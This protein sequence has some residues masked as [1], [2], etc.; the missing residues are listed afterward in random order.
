MSRV[1]LALNV[2]TTDEVALATTRLNGEGLETQ[3]E[4]QT[5]CCFA[6]QDKVWVQGLNN[7]PWEV[8]TVLSDAP[9]MKLIPVSGDSG[10]CCS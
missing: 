7:E 2:K 1:Q 8:Y 10:T 9:T 4:E 5:T 6:V 3:V